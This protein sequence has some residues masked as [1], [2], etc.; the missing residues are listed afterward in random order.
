MF[1][2]GQLSNGDFDPAIPGPVFRRIVVG[3]WVRFAVTFSN[4]CFPTK[5][6]RGWLATDDAGHVALVGEYFRRSGRWHAPSGQLRTPPDNAGDPLYAVWATSR[7]GRNAPEST[8]DAQ[9]E[10]PESP[11]C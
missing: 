7:V 1:D 6:I 11:S 9:Q 4:R 10:G 5:A 8:P 2:L 3:D